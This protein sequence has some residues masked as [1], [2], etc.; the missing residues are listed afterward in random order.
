MV[1]NERPTLIWVLGYYIKLKFFGG[2]SA[3]LLQPKFDYGN[4]QISNQLV[5]HYYV[6]VGYDYA[7]RPEV[8]NTNLLSKTRDYSNP[9]DL[10]V[11]AKIRERFQVGVSYRDTSLQVLFL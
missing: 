8:I 2:L 3:K 6:L 5:R 7:L 11:I 9:A 1:K 4:D 10:S